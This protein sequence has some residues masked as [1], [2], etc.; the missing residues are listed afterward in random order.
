MSAP[1]RLAVV[2]AR[3]GDG[4]VGGAEIAL[5]EMGRGLALR[6]WDIEVLTTCAR[7]HYTWENV[8]PPGVTQD[9]ELT[10]RRFPAVVDTPG[11]DRARLEARIQAGEELTAAEQQ[12]WMNDGMR[13]P[14]LYHHLAEHADRYR[15]VVFAPY[16][17]WPTYACSLAAP[18][19]SVVMPCLHD[20]PY[21]RLPLFRPVMQGVAGL[22]FLTEPERELARR[23][24]APLAPEACVGSGVAVPQS[25]DPDGFR[26][27]HGLTR[28]Y[29]LYAGRR[30]GGKGWE[31]L[32]DGFVAATAGSSLPFD[33]VTM[34]VGDVDAPPH[35]AARVVDLGFLENA[36]R[37]DAFAA[38]AAYLQ[39]SRV[40]SFSRT[41]ME[42][43]LAGT[44]VIANGASEVM[45]WHVQRSGAGLVYDDDVELEECLAFVAAAPCA[46]RDIG[47]HGR[48][49]VLENYTWDRVLDRVEHALDRF[50]PL[51]GGR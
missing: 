29:L 13:V 40:E 27:R 36:E 49:Y 47:A 50:V 7:N 10:V 26:A 51:Q 18:E 25:Y 12:R 39:P 2:P 48:R 17:F 41:A 34:G 31:R 1:G 21:A 6:G 8:F 24:A 46:A 35:M 30:E 3:Y 44:P 32:L 9:G 22:L 4:V 43:W 37:D 20:E 23:L 45:R 19:R 33:L 14:A 5:A 42:A 11:R 38:A 15:A 16:P 28:P